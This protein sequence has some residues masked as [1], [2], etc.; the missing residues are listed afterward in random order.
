MTSV[1]ALAQLG[2]SVWIDTLDRAATRSGDLAAKLAKG[3]GGVVANPAHFTSAIIERDD[4]RD[5]LD[6]LVAAPDQ[7]A[8]AI[9]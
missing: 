8:A 5:V 4:Y 1:E 3:V 9:Y 7:D 6:K 2:Q